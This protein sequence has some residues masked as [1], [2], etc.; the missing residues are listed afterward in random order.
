MNSYIEIIPF[1]KKGK[2]MVYLV[3]SLKNDD[4]LG[5]IKWYNG[6][7]RYVFMPID[8]VIF[9][10]LC[11]GKIKDFIDNLMNARNVPKDRK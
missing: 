3:R 8:D 9:D 2:T 7:R 11:L 10:S 6:W 4:V 5:Q 1:E